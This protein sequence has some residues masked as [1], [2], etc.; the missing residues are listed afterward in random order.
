MAEKKDEK[1]PPDPV[2]RAA[3]GATAGPT[4]GPLAPQPEAD[5]EPEKLAKGERRA[6]TSLKYEGVRYAPGSPV[7][8]K[9][10]K[11][12]EPYET[13]GALEKK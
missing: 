8:F 13:A 3:A 10:A 9:S 4:T 11:D 2:A 7:P 6:R 1:S 5:A 12:A